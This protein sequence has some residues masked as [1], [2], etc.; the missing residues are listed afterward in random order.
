MDFECRCIRTHTKE[1]PS[2]IS[3]IKSAILSVKTLKLNG[4]P[5]YSEKISNA[6]QD[7]SF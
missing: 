5:E 1:K 3:N 4:H 7:D 2:H 6:L